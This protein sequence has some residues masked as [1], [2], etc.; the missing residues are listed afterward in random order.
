MTF[1]FYDFSSDV[2]KKCLFIPDQTP[3]INQVYNCTE[4][5]WISDFIVATYRCLSSSFL[6]G[7]SLQKQT[8]GSCVT[9]FP[10]PAWVITT[11]C[12][13]PGDC[14]PF[15]RKLNQLTIFLAPAIIIVY[16]AWWSAL[17]SFVRF[18]SFPNLGSFVCSLNLVSL[19]KPSICSNSFQEKM[20]KFQGK[21]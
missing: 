20:F 14:C 4:A 8:E 5:L 11:H 12:C 19:I 17:E 21:S 18:S 6:T 3:M 2:W 13:I 16:I 1:V 7:D 10:T 15:I 9:K